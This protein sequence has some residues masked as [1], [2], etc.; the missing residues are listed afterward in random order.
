MAN[1]KRKNYGFFNFV[2][3]VILTCLTGGLWLIWI[4]CRE[5]RR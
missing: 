3:D 4:F 5:M 2:L 1:N